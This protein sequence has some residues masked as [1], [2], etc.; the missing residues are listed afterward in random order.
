MA[1]EH[2][3]DRVGVAPAGRIERAAEFRRWIADGCH[4]DMTWM[5]HRLDDRLDPQRRRPEIA[6]W[7]IVGASYYTETPDATLWADRRRGRV[8]RYAWGPDYH[9]ILGSR[10]RQLS[11]GIRRAAGLS[12]APWWFVDA[13]PVPEK[14]LA[15]RAGLGFVGRNSLVISPLTGSWLHLGGLG[16]P[17][18]AAQDILPSTAADGCGLCRRCMSACPTDALAVERRV[19]ARRCIAWMTVECQ[20][21]IPEALRPRVGRW[22]AGCDECQECCPWNGPP[23]AR[24]SSRPWLAFNPRLHSPPLAEA[25]RLDV[26]AFRE[27]YEGTIIAR[28]GWHRWIR[29]ALV[30]AASATVD[31]DLRAAAAIHLDATDPL[32]REHAM[33]LVRR[34][35]DADDRTSDAGDIGI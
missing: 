22:L 19:D 18:N 1:L 30:A 28:I 25:L 29:N 14:A 20:G 31:A 24:P 9:R 2:G 27:R 12:A 8:A 23:R 7:L 15:A 6:A 34:W 16:L 33:W 13:R 3:F 5:A 32:I 26:A 35:R 17:W 4:A 21:V 10:L 11:E